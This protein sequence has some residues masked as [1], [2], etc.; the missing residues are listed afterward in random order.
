MKKIVSISIGSSKRDHTAE[1][2]VLGS[3]YQIER[4][5]TDGSLT[6][7]V[8]LIKSLDGKVEAFGMGGID[9]YLWGGNRRYTIREAVKLKKAATKTPIVDGS[10]L[11][12]TLERD[13][14]YQL[15]QDKKLE[16]VD[17]T[18]LIPCAMDRF[19][20]AEAIE[21]CGGR[22]I[23]GDL[24][25]ALGFHKPIY[26]LKKLHRIAT[27]VAPFVCQLPFHLLYP[28]GNRQDENY[29]TA[30]ASYYKAAD[31]IAGDF[32]YIKRFMPSS[33][34]NKIIITNT[35][36]ELDVEELRSRGVT[37]LVTTTPELEGRSFGTNVMEALLVAVAMDRGLDAT[38]RG[39]NQLLKEFNFK[40]RV[41]YLRPIDE[42]CIE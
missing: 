21:A 41:E 15:H 10:G 4:I 28:I 20:M 8:D 23:L 18:V 42:N 29:S 22:L 34:D 1:I 25:F 19:G 9:L 14:I 3:K 17:K 11:K 33:L 36:T 24:I 39:Y 2:E 32:H 13:V 27:F 12:N 31:I 7:A 35:V 30:K 16:F 37:I 40:P 38:P 26:S 6:K 5:G